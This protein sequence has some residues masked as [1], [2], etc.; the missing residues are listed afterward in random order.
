MRLMPLLLAAL[1]VGC[2]GPAPKDTGTDSGDTGLT[3][4]L[5]GD[6]YPEEDG[7][8]DD[9]DATVHPGADEVWYDGIDE[10]CDGLDDFDQDGDGAS[11]DSDCNDEDST[12]S[13][14]AVEVCD[15]I[16]N[17]CDEQVDETG[18]T[19]AFLDADGDGFGTGASLGTYCDLPEGTSSNADDCDDTDGAVNPS[20]AEVCNGIDD[21]CDGEADV[22]ATDAHLVYADL[23]GDGFG[24]PGTAIALCED[25]PD[26]VLDGTDCDDT[27]NL[28]FPAAAELCDLKDNDCDGAVDEDATEARTYYADADAD[29]YGDLAVT[30][31]GC[32]APAGYVE[33]STDCNDADPTLSPGVIEICDGID[34]DCDGAVDIDSPDA[35]AYHP[36]GDLDGYG[37]PATTEMGCSPLDG[38]VTDDTDCNDADATVSPGA[39]ELCD[40]VDDNCDGA[41]DESTAEDAPS[42]Y[43]DADADGYGDPD[44][45]A[46]ACAQPAGFVADGT[47]CDDAESTV[48]PA[49][50]EV[51]DGVD[52][53]CDGIVDDGASDA[54]TWY[55][56]TDEDGYGDAS[57]MTAAC[58]QP[59]GTVADSTDCDDTAADAYPG[60]LESCDGTDQDCDGVVDNDP[61][62]GILLYS[63]ADGDGFGDG[64]LSLI[65]CAESAGWVEDGS[66]C[67]DT[68][69]DVNPAAVETC[70]AQDND[71]DGSVDE[72]SAVDAGT[73]YDDA[74]RDGYGDPAVA[75]TA[76]D[77][78]L[79]SIADATDCD[80]ADPTAYPGAVEYCDGADD[81][82]DGTVDEPSAA[83]AST[84]YADADGDAY[85]NASASTVACSAPAGN[86]ADATDC[87]D[88]EADAHPGAT[89]ICDGID[90]DCDGR[91]DTGATD[92]STWYA[93]ADGDGYGN[94]GAA[95]VACTAPAGSVA[96]AT[97]CDDT[98]SA[99]YPGATE[100][101]DG[102]DDDCDGSV[103]EAGA[104]GESEW[105][106]DADGD[107]YGVSST[108]VD[109]CDLPS[110]YAAVAGDCDDAVA[111]TWPS[112]PE[113][114]N[115]VDDDC[116]D[117]VDE[118][119]VAVGD[120]VI[121][122][123]S[124]QPRFGATSTNTNGQWFEIYNASTRDIDLSNWYF[125]R[126]A[127]TLAADH[128]YVDPDDDVILA[129]G[130][131]AVFCKTDNYTASSTSYSTL[132]CDYFWGDETQSSSYSGTYHDNTFNLQRDQDS[133]QVYFGGNATTGTMMDTVSWYYDGTNGY[134]PRDA[135]RSLS[136]D[137]A[138]LDVTSNDTRSSWCS[139]SNSA[140][141]AWYNFSS[142]NREYGTPGAA[143]YD[144]P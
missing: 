10:N 131:Y 129:A 86:V 64:V 2:D 75:T 57:A 122:E 61:T 44:A 99:A 24:D 95:T 60:A 20:A 102:I 112:A 107:G 141:Y 23:D 73:W 115:L 12:I 51:C 100:V 55:A 68:L 45:F 105:F 25:A 5:D 21:D 35:V 144:C 11:N 72:P 69:A 36:D 121:S 58:E 120:V 123:I 56:D 29:G 7:D 41:V 48:N 84:W 66:D 92:A 17:N 117:F 138:A 71:C 52:Q 94:A 3:S 63:D 79:G 87:D 59:A 116:D 80:D 128:F 109:A 103:D 34:N 33:S 137:P 106:L 132:Q 136:L 32:G 19:D 85:G 77:A 118:D 62:D 18:A 97:D 8:C 127:A 119:F 30:A 37:D 91:I 38:Y 89:E 126:V 67:D 54:A 9:G 78:P 70:D 90:D 104:D 53:D 98:S 47:D 114:D 4:D 42:W 22:G 14:D 93:D 13:P 39:L 142:G 1:F 65:G 111:T 82:C 113:L 88:A 130:D 27:D 15:G 31:V 26:T 135:T 108:T 40:G 83:D 101:C 96:D 50:A 81:N 133:L 139:T 28:T 76:C 46:P 6:G 43:L 143:N 49:G 124:R 134:W 140:A 110:G 74:D 125:Q 16:D